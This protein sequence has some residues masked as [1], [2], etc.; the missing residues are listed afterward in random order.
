M[1]QS[2]ALLH[3]GHHGAVVLGEMRG[4][5]VKVAGV[6]QNAVVEDWR[7]GTQPLCEQTRDKDASHD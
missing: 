7:C 6:F 2:Q 3:H 1:I 5:A 4:I